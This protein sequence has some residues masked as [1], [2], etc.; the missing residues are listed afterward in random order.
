MQLSADANRGR[1]DTVAGNNDGPELVARFGRR[2]VLNDRSPSG[3]PRDQL[4]R[5]IPGT[6]AQVASIGSG[7]PTGGR[8][9]AEPGGRSHATRNPNVPAPAASQALPVTKPMRSAGE[10]ARLRAEL[11]HRG[12]RLEPAGG[13]DGQGVIDVQAG[14]PQHGIE[15]CR[16]RVRQDP[17]S[18]AAF[19]ERVEHA[20]EP[21][22]ARA[23]RR[24]RRMRARLRPSRPPRPSRGARDRARPR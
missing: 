14:P 19:P 8:A 7:A 9:A 13:V 23:G 5:K 16:G 6:S 1:S 22:E 17:G 15:R 11:V 21:P 2:Q 24:R 12:M 4:P 20:G 10:A 3:L 18:E